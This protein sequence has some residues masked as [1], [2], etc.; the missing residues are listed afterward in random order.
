MGKVVYIIPGFQEYTKQPE[1]KKIGSFFKAKGFKVVYTDI[2][3]NYKV[4]SNYVKEFT[5][6]YKFDQK[7]DNYFIGFSFGAVISFL[8][9]AKLKPKAQILCSLSGVFKEDF[10]TCSPEFEKIA[11]KYCRKRRV[12]DLKK[13]SFNKLYPNVKCKSIILMG[14]SELKEM[15]KRGKDAHKKLKKSKLIIVPNNKHDIRKKE[16]MDAIKEVIS[17]L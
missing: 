8:A 1:Y 15:I 2:T 17:K 12:N 5:T 4:M 9:S 11:Y 6:K 13:I 14:D 3:W 7:N 10:A 16:Y